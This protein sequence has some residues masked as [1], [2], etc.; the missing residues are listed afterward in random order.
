MTA[1]TAVGFT[2]QHMELQ[3]EVEVLE[4]E[5]QQ[6]EPKRAEFQ[7][8]M[9]D[10]DGWLQA[11]LSEEDEMI[12]HLEPACRD[13]LDQHRKLQERHNQEEPNK[14]RGP[15]FETN[16]E[17]RQEKQKVKPSSEAKRLFRRIS[18]LCHPDKTP[19]KTWLHE[20][21]KMASEAY[22]NNNVK[23]LLDI[24]DGLV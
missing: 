18:L 1:N 9:D 8:M 12:T 16:F 24:W 6:L 17:K 4:I 15:N 14:P 22:E 23:A 19:G 13:L 21:F 2:V 11:E 20:F 7:G 5:C 10:L 3:D